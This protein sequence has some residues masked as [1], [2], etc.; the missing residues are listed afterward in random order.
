MTK[1]RN[2][3]LLETIA[4]YIYRAFT[5]EYSAA[6]AFYK[7]S[8]ERQIGFEALERGKSYANLPAEGKGKYQMHFFALCKELRD[9]GVKAYLGFE[10]VQATMYKLRNLWWE[11]AGEVS[12]KTLEYM[13]MAE[14][15][16]YF[17]LI[18]KQKEIF[19]KYANDLLDSAPEIEE[20]KPASENLNALREAIHGFM[21]GAGK[22]DLKSTFGVK[23]EHTYESEYQKRL[24]INLYKPFL[25]NLL[26]EQKEQIDLVA[27]GTLSE[28]QG[29][30]YSMEIAEDQLLGVVQEFVSDL[31]E[32]TLQEEDVQKATVEKWAKPYADLTEEEK[33]SYD[34]YL[35]RLLK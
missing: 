16:S 14:N 1:E 18:P 27:L 32:L 7:G 31:L 6:V 23:K 11:I 33:A 10:N 8:S 35:L 21:A 5:S 9:K 19:V 13:L 28:L 24:A 15:V 3:D 30:G 22:V 2:Q 17:V 12:P 29:K 25:N 4:S 20:A 26:A 34:K